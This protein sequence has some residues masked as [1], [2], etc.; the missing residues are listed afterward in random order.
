MSIAPAGP[1]VLNFK[2]HHKQ[3]VALNA[4]AQ[5]VVYGGAAGG[6]KSHLMRV[7]FILWAM[8][9]PGLQLYLFRRTVNDLYKNHMTGPTSFY[10]LLYPLRAA[11]L[12]RIVKNEIRFWNESRIWLQHCQHEKDVE[13]YKGYEFHVLGL[14]E[15]TTFTEKQ[16]RFLQSRMR[17]PAA[18]QIPD[19]LKGLFP[20][21]LAG[22]NPGGVGHHY[23]KEQY[24]DNGAFNVVR[25]NKENGGRLR[26]FIPAK[27]SDNPSLPRE[28]YEATLHGLGDAIL[29]RAMLDGD[30]SAVSGAMFG[31]AWRAPR[32]IIPAFCIPAGWPLWRSM[33]DGYSAPASIH[34]WTEDPD[35]KTLYV[36]G[37]IYRAGLLPEDVAER[38]ITKDL[39]IPTLEYDGSFGENEE[40]LS[41]LIDPAAFTDNGNSNG[42]QKTIARGNVMNQLGCRWKPAAKGPGSRVQRAQ[43]LHRLLKANPR[44]P[45]GMPGI[46]FF[47]ECVNAIKQIPTLPRSANNPED[48]D[49]NVEDHAYDSICYG[50]QW[51][52]PNGGLTRVS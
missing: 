41:G 39:T 44:D 3:G 2:L 48:V 33:D 32:H 4:I 36:I 24:V 17:I 52:Q 28:E 43:H 9:I 23:V 19:H 49:T 18:L 15:M 31:D 14:D 29:V 5:E 20:R 12:C 25:A 6:G 10:Q 34:W 13:N 45:R 8:Q 50:V 40:I 51:K 37:E 47:P 38:C 42:K 7:A 30:W 1:P 35:I 26:V 16:I 22:T 46:R 21:M 27:V 11:G